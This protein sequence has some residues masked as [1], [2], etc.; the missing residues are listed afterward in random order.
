MLKGAF[1]RLRP[2]D[3]PLL[4]SDQGRQYQMSL[5]QQ[6]IKEK[7]LTQSISRKGNCLDNA[8]MENWFG[9]N[10]NRIP[11]QEEV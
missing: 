6:A 10:E 1:K 7:G 5:Y 9:K 8:V 11:P 2:E 3:K 4:H